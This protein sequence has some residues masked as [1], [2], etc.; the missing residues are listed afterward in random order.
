[1]RL[2]KLGILDQSPIGTGENATTALWHTIEL[3]RRADRLG[4]SRFWVSEHHD[5][6]SLAGSSPEVL[7]SAIGSHTSHIRIG[8]GGV[9][10]P[11]YS[12]YKVA[13]NFRILEGL[14]PGRVDLGIG[15]APGGMPLSSL[16]LRG[17]GASS[18]DDKLPEMLAELGAYLETGAPL[19]KEHPLAGLTATPKVGTVP[20]IWLLGS[21]GFSAALAARM[22][23]K[24]SY[25]QFINGNGGQSATSEYSRGYRPGPLGRKPQV[26]VCV[27]VV[28]ADSDL[29]AEREAKAMDL[30]L[31]Q[32]EKGEYFRSFPTPE[33]AAAY[34]YTEWERAR[35]AENRKRMIVGGPARVR[36]S[37]LALADSYRTDEV[38]VACMMSDF[39]LRLRCYELLADLFF[40]RR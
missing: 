7:L 11:H 35:I 34:P 12:P 14:Y 21:S 6:G 8:S 10:L 17:D 18:R 27:F 36:S 16:A 15:R 38:L 3:A 30:R 19:P 40:L 13:E 20:E 2:L 29:I 31:L 24:F 9:L 32:Q 28:C 1:M 5:S 23:A 37:L 25:A 4:Y 39:R 33:E 22:G 26:S